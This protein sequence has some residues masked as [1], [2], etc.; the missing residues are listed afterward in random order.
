MKTRSNPRSKFGNFEKFIRN[1]RT[2]EVT[3]VVPANA[4][5]QQKAA[6]ERLLRTDEA[7]KLTG[8]RP[9]TIRQFCQQGRLTAVKGKYDHWQITN[10]PLLWVKHDAGPSRVMNTRFA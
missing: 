8:Y 5:K 7:V 6:V 10:D 4:K 2:E 3:N 1:A 9:R